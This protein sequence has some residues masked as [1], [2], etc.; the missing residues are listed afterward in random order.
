MK[1]E[2]K[3]NKITFSEAPQVDVPGAL[4]ILNKELKSSFI[5]VVKEKVTYRFPDG[6][7]SKDIASIY[8][9]IM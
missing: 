8:L 6:L 1:F 5:D 2:L 7:T 4:L 9:R 3:K